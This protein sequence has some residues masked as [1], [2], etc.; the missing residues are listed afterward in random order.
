MSALHGL[1]GFIKSARD[2]AEEAADLEINQLKSPIGKHDQYM[3]A[4]GGFLHLIYR[5]E[6]GVTVRKVNVNDAI[7]KKLE[8]ELILVFSGMKRSASETL[9]V[10]AKRFESS[11]EIFADISVFRKYGS[12]LRNYLIN[13]HIE[14]FAD[15]L[16]TLMAIKKQCFANCTNEKLD[17]FMDEGYRLGAV[18]AKVIGAGGGGFVYFYVPKPNQTKFK[19][20]ITEAGGTVYP[21]SFVEAGSKIVSLS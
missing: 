12:G 7:V 10:T 5:K 20:G 14:N 8:S 4:Y 3:A 15:G 16:K 18:G 11:K 19:K 17:K 9:G 6:G 13:N 1:K 21:F 2:L